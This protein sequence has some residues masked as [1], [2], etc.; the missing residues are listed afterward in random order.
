MKVVEVMFDNFS[1]TQKLI[2]L[3]LVDM[4]RHTDVYSDE[5]IRNI[6]SEKNMSVDL[7]LLKSRKVGKYGIKIESSSSSPIARFANFSNLMEI[8]K[9]FPNQIPPDVVIENS[10][11]ANKENIIDRI[12]PLPETAVTGAKVTG[13]K[14]KSFA[15]EPAEDTEKKTVSS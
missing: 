3:G 2:T 1:R 5:E 8:V 11:L 15:T 9:T 6:V 10:D 4:V 14:G 13:D 12:V 7:S